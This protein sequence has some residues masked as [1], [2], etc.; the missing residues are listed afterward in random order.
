MGLAPG[1]WGLEEKIEV[2]LLVCIQVCGIEERKAVIDNDAAPDTGD[3]RLDKIIALLNRLDRVSLPN[4]PEHV[5]LYNK[6][7][8]Q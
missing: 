5:R 1:E 2:M 3:A 8:L 7:R 6:V 4:M